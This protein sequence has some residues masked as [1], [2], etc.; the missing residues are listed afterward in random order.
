MRARSLS[1]FSIPFLLALCCQA[2]QPDTKTLTIAISATLG[3]ILKGPDPLGVNGQTGSLTVQASESLTPV[4]HTSNEATYTLPSGA[5]T[6][7]L[8]GMPFTTTTA[9]NISVK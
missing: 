4:S 1:L 5:I 3:P 2:A 9:S 8:F 7:V 6:V